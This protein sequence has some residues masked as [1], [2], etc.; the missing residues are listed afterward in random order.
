MHLQFV[1]VYHS[2]DGVV[3]ENPNIKLLDKV[4][5]KLMNTFLAPNNYQNN[6]IGDIQVAVSAF[7][8]R[9]QL[10]VNNEG[11]TGEDTIKSIGYIYWGLYKIYLHYMK[12]IDSGTFDFKFQDVSTNRP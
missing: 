5:D 6:L 11:I 2:Y 7:A 1:G 12:L 9:W 8:P 10:S 4:K 3:R